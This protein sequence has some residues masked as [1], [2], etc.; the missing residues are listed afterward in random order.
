MAWE[1]VL[2]V[3][4]NR[5]RHIVDMHVQDIEHVSRIE[6]LGVHCHPASKNVPALLVN[7][8]CD[9]LNLAILLAPHFLN[10]TFVGC[11]DVVLTNLNGEAIS[12]ANLL[13]EAL[14]LDVS[15]LTAILIIHGDI[16]NTVLN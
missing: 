7:A 11:D 8:L 16:A 13:W 12:L 15:I 14:G 5:I 2:H 1:H 9:A 6:L 4:C 3:H 10:M